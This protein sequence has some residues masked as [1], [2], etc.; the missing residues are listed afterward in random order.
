MMSM[1]VCPT[2]LNNPT[3]GIEN[4]IEDNRQVRNNRNND[5]LGTSD[6]YA[7]FGM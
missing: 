7:N 6:S 1:M 4:S 3:I 2:M 5:L